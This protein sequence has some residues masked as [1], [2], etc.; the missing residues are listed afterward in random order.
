M[1]YARSVGEQLNDLLAHIRRTQNPFTVLLHLVCVWFASLN[2]YIKILKFCFAGAFRLLK[3]LSHRTKNFMLNAVG[4]Q[5]GWQ[6]MCIRFFSIRAENK[7]KKTFPNK[8]S[9]IHIHVY[10]FI[11]WKSCV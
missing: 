7:K 3:N 4:A 1:R 6:L 11:E 9:D 5:C 8:K 10:S 2:V